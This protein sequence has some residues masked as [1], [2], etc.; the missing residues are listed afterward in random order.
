MTP[1][2]G[3]WK[4]TILCNKDVFSFTIF[5]QLQWPIEP[6]FE[7][8]CYFMHVLGFTK[9][10][11]WSWTI[12]KSITCL[13]KLPPPVAM[14]RDGLTKKT[15]TCRWNVQRIKK[16]CT[17]YICYNVASAT[18]LACMVILQSLVSLNGRKVFSLTVNFSRSSSVSK[19]SITLTDKKGER[20]REFN[21][22]QILFYQYFTNQEISQIFTF[23][24]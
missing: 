20:E 18:G 22:K 4:H 6:K 24:Q 1:F 9:W 2:S 5:L 21:Q 13:F 7:Q 3:I 8:L 23:L 10:D 16:S 17:V 19:P 14:S 15:D 12:T 11:Y